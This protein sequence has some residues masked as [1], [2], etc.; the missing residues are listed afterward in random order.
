MVIGIYQILNKL[1]NKR[2]IGSSKNV[3]RRLINHRAL[4]KKGNHC[5]IHLQSAYNKDGLENLEFKLILECRLEDLLFYE[6]S[7]IKGYQSTNSE[8]GYNFKLPSQPTYVTRNQTKNAQRRFDE[9]QKLT[10]LKFNR[11]TLLEE[12]SKDKHGRTRW[13]TLCDC[14]IEK[15]HDLSQVKLG[16]I[17]SCGCARI[18]PEK[19]QSRHKH[20][21]KIA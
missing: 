21:R 4:L 2:Y 9:R 20:L 5:N 18:K 17:Q 8:L 6:E 14:G 7:I 13:K 11:L 12:V 3:S 15:I 1:N 16:T 10:G 19:P